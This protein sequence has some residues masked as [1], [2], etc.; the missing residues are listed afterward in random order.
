MDNLKNMRNMKNIILV[1]SVLLLSFSC[2]KD[3][4]LNEPDEIKF[5]IGFQNT[6]VTA[7]AFEAGD[8]ISVWA[9]EQTGS[10]AI[11]LQI[12]G[13]YINNEKLSY[14]G[15][16]WSSA[17]T[18][19]WSESPC[20]FYAVYPYMGNVSSV[21]EQPFQI[22]QDQ[23]TEKS[24]DALGGYEA[25]DLLYA[26]AKNV[27]RTDG[28]VSLQF[29]HLLSKC[30]IKVIKGESFEGEI[31]DDIVVHI[32]N[33]TTS[34]ILNLQKGSV[35]KDQFGSKKTITAKKISNTQFEA[36][37]LPQNIEK[38]TPLIEV[39]MGGIAYLLE[40][41]LS[42]RPGYAHTINLTV[43]TSP[44]QEQI[45]ISIDPGTSGWGD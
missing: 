8:N 14:N 39:T 33:T 40:Y 26:S 27:A 9:V 19:Y 32:Y 37:V 15:T 45:E 42:F 11:P 23:N 20:D 2:S 24:G 43:N 6:K 13:N 35:E 36:V 12:G 7:T 1:I 34:G 41:S 5:N 44:D 18:L 3:N 21:E 17:R 16:V 38:R 25:S 30:V 10:E 31:P 28:A 22:Q 4:P 29:R